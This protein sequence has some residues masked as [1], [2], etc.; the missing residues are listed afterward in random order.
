MEELLLT[1]TKE[2]LLVDAEILPEIYRKFI[3]AEE[4]LS[5]HL[6]GSVSDAC[7]RAGISRTAFYKYRGKV[8]RVE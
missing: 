1:K 7:R 3:R 6:A 8:I 5:C 4:L 2:L